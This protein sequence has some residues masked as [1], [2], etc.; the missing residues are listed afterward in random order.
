LAVAVLLGMTVHYVS[1]EDEHGGTEKKVSI[2]SVPAKVK[3]A[4]LEAVGKGRLVDIG[5]ITTPGG[6]VFYE[7]E[8]WLAGKEYD[9][10]FDAEGNVLKRELDSEEDEGD[11]EEEDDEFDGTEKKVSLD[12]VPAPVKA[13]IQKAVGKGR[14]VDIGEITTQGGSTVYEIEMWQGDVE[15]DVVFSTAGQELQRTIEHDGHDDKAASGAWKVRP[16]RKFVRGQAPSMMMLTA[17]LKT[18][19]EVACGG[20]LVMVGPTTKRGRKYLKTGLILDGRK[21]D[22][23]LSPGGAELKRKL[24]CIGGK[25]KELLAGEEEDAEEE[26]H[27]GTEKKVSI[28]RVPAKVKAAILAEVGTGKLVDIGE[29]TTPGGK[30]FYEIEMWI[31]GKE[32]DVLFSADGKVLKK[33]VED[34]E[35]DEDDDE[36]DDDEEDDD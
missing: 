13:A 33:E 28:D 34:E 3:A 6:K 31:G 35:D 7:I 2:E 10:L 21:Y 11:G 19:V 23:L 1:G 8:M 24:A 26:E 36:D 4:I 12:Q 32:Y 20:K 22:L 5:E 27:G 14:L 18:V 25:G 16:S 9:V 15:Y 17:L 30:T 29:I